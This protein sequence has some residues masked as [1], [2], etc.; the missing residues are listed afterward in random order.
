M[1]IV[2]PNVDMDFAVNGLIPTK[3]KAGQPIELSNEDV[4]WLA[5]SPKNLISLTA[6]GVKAVETPIKRRNRPV[7]VTKEQP[8]EIK[9]IAEDAKE[10]AEETKE[11]EG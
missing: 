5:K 8:E 2:Y 4:E 6:P 1:T 3:L 9:E 11:V 7:L 10:L